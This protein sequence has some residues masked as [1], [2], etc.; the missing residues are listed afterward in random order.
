[1]TERRRDL[2][3]QLS[4][5]GQRQAEPGQQA[6]VVGQETPYR[7]VCVALTGSGVFSIVHVVPFH[8]SAR[9]TQPPELFS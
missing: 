9:E 3:G 4:A 5:R 6:V 8:A 2:E 7:Y 1:M